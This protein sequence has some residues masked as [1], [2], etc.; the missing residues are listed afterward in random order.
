MAKLAKE[1]LKLD[2]EVTVVTYSDQLYPEIDDNLDYKVRR[3]IRG[4]KFSNYWRYYK[5]LT[6]LN[7]H[8][9]YDLIYSFDH[10]SAGIP[11]VLV[12]HKFKRPL[13]IRVGGDFIWERYLDKNNNLVTL[14]Q[15]YKQR[16][17]LSAEKLRFQIIKWVFKKTSKIIFTTKFQSDIFQ[18]YYNLPEN[19]LTLIK[20]PIDK[21]FTKQYKPNNSKQIILPEDLS[22]KI[23]SKI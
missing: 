16:W 14:S 3:I 13:F 12:N 23:I 7:N 18:K 15:F 17:H 5:K 22:I 2:H 6:E 9:S 20:N 1:F 10:F 4:N 21:N 11:A 19:K 8:T